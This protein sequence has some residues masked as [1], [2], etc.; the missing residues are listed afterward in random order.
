M[1]TLRI[2]ATKYTPKIILDINGAIS[3]VGKSYPENSYEFYS[4]V[5]SWIKKYFEGSCSNET[6]ID[7][8]ITYLNSTSSKV[9][10]SIFTL[11]DEFK[12]NNKIKINWICDSENESA[13]EF[14]NDFIED[15]PD[16]DIEIVIVN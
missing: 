3:F 11:F 6:I 14:G 12:E 8:N 15:F 9:F 16:L 4:P 13:E 1:E 2:E 5:L 7:L 10:F